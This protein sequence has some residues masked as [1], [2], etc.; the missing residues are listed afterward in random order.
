MDENTARQKA[1]YIDRGFEYSKLY[2]IAQDS[3]RLLDST[4]LVKNSQLLMKN[5]QVET[6]LIQ[7][8]N[9]EKKAI[10]NMDLAMLWRSKATKRSGKIAIGVAAG[11]VAGYLIH[12]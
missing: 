9:A 12:R 8:N 6:S 3:I 7:R 5:Y 4:I 10:N 1:I 2:R 11:F